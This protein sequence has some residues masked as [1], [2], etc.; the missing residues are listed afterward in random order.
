MEQ[1]PYL[2]P[3]GL[4]DSFKLKN[5]HDEIIVEILTLDALKTA[6]DGV[7]D[8]SLIF[9]LDGRNDFAAWI[10]NVIGCRA[11]SKEFAKIKLNEKH[12]EETRRQLVKVLDY[13]L[14]LLKE[15]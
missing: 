15:V 5:D 7:S 9:H 6:I 8:T 3:V 13:T 4:E 10:E 11:L 2:R 1:H 14:S 12:P